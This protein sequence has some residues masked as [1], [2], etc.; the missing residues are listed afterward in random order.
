MREPCHLF[1]LIPPGKL[2]AQEPGRTELTRQTLSTVDR[3]DHVNQRSISVPAPKRLDRCRGDLIC[4]GF[5]T[6]D[7]SSRP[8]CHLPEPLLMPYFFASL[9]VRPSI[10]LSSL[11]AYS[12]GLLSPPQVFLPLFYSVSFL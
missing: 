11:L 1:I 4:Q 9:S 8:I 10:L 3:P 12:S 7:S 2:G 5:R 6:S